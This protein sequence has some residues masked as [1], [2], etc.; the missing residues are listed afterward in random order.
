MVTKVCMAVQ[1]VR[2]VVHIQLI[3]HAVQRK[4]C[5][6]HTVGIRPDGRPVIG[7]VYIISVQ[8][9]IAQYYIFR[10]PVFIRYE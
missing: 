4:P 7:A 5:I 3:G 10:F 6:R 9:I 8:I 2:P 1:V